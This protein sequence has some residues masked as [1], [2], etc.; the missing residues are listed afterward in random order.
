MK[1]TLFKSGSFKTVVFLL[2]FLV[3]CFYYQVD[4]IM[5]AYPQSVHIWRQ[6]NSLSLTQNYYQDNLPFFKPAVHNQFCDD[7][8]SGQSIDE[9]P[10]V[11]YGVATLWK[12]FGNHI[13][14]FRV[15]QILIL[16]CGLL[17]LFKSLEMFIKNAFWAG[18]LTLL[19]M[20]SPM[21]IFY[22]I[23]FLPDVPA[24]S[25]VIIAWYFFF[26]SS[27]SPDHKKL[28]IWI[29][30]LFFFL[31]GTIKITAATTYVA[32]AGWIVIELL[33]IKKDK[34]YFNFSITELLP[35]T[36]VFAGIIL[37]NLYVESYN[38]KHGG[39]ISFHNIWPIWNMTEEQI[40]KVIDALRKIYL[41]QMFWPWLQ[42]VT[43]IIWLFLMA[44]FRKFPLIIR[45]S[46][47]I[48]PLGF[49]L[50][51]LLWFQVF[52]GHD[53]YLINL[54]I[55]LVFIWA[56]FIG[57]MIQKRFFHHPAIYIV[58]VL[59]LLFNIFRCQRANEE[60]YDGWMNEWYTKN[61]KALSEMEPYFKKWNIGTD[62]KVIS[63]PDYSINASLYFMNRKGYTDFGSNF[64]SEEVF[65]K[66]IGQGAKYLVIND[67]TYLQ[68]QFVKPFIMNKIGEYKN[69]Q[70]FDLQGIEMKTD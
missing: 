35:L 43:I 63:L 29:A 27:E 58:A 64:L 2:S 39:S 37:W 59:F 25:F 56:V 16:F 70:V 40:W 34:R 49:L 65:Y 32:L 57:F 53:Y 41:K 31:A 26:R 42:L 18:F 30:S 67:S 60:R 48:L 46:L 20:T 21:I 5:D 62:D 23:N 66:R 47:V 6:T 52:E 14:I 50:F 4:D 3:L 33:F 15:V 7:G 28:F 55:I 9:F 1:T 38:Q 51:V 61:L 36:L 11:Y 10:V 68:N 22:G 17:A 24:L 19:L 45:Y 44:N 12:I 13:W 54:S 8:I 69:V